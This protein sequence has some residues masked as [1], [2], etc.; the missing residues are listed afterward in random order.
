MVDVKTLN[1][2]PKSSKIVKN[3]LVKI[4]SENKSKFRNS[5]PKAETKLLIRDSSTEARKLQ[6]SKS[7]TE[8]DDRIRTASE[9]NKRNIKK[10]NNSNDFKSNNSSPD[11]ESE[12]SSPE[13]RKEMARTS[14]IIKGPF[15]RIDE[16]EGYNSE[17]SSEDE[18]EDQEI[19]KLNKVHNKYKQSDEVEYVSA[20]KYDL[21]AKKLIDTENKL[22][23]IELNSKKKLEELASQ[24]KVYIPI[25]FTSYVK[26]PSKPHLNIETYKVDNNLNYNIIDPAVINNPQ[27]IKNKIL[28]GDSRKARTVIEHNPKLRKIT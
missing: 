27:Q 17:H 4:S 24:V 1:R 25:N 13:K 16:K 14:Y 11:K 28:R 18:K 2:P 22:L 12:P 15:E 5:N 26:P 7:I 6:T 8:I 20:A 23:E 19:L 21:L 9:S 10:L 3:N